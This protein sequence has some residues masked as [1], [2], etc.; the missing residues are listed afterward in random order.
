[1]QDLGGFSWM[2]LA[3]F[4]RDLMLWSRGRTWKHRFEAMGL[5]RAECFAGAR[6]Y[7]AA[8]T[9]IG[10]VMIDRLTEDRGIQ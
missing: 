1:M 6:G 5:A 10:I 8:A 4:A 7:A 3:G 9:L 2:Q